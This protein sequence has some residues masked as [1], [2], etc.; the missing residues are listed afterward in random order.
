MQVENTNLV[1][2]KGALYFDQFGDT[3]YVGLGERYF[4]NSPSVAFQVSREVEVRRDCVGGVLV[5][6]ES[7]V[8]SE[9]AVGSVTTDNISPEN[10]ALWFGAKSTGQAAM[11]GVIQTPA[12]VYQGR[13]YQLGVTED[14]PIG[15]RDFSAV[16]VT[17]AGVAVPPLNNYIPDPDNGR[18]TILPGSAI[19]DGANVQ[20]VGTAKATNEIILVSAGQ[21]QTGSLRFVADAL[22]GKGHDYFFPVVELQASGDFQLK[23][24]TWQEL[25]FSVVARKRP[26]RKLYYIASRA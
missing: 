10:V 13:T 2:G 11:A 12:K 17:L 4:G 16:S 20:L 19:A 21:I 24:D 9:E 3:P 25:Q 22:H 1:L 15:R 26:K 8:I 23:G 14:N 6:G 5:R 18:I 7:F